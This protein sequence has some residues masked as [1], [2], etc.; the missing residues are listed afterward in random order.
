M[1]P[2][3]R[4]PICKGFCN[5]HTKTICKGPAAMGPFQKSCWD[6]PKKLDSACSRFAPAAPSHS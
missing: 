1:L 2:R 4:G 5:K 6:K 3:P